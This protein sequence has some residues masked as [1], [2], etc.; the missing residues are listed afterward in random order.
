MLGTY[1]TFPELLIWLPLLAGVACFF[2]KKEQAAKAIALLG[3]LLVL[4]VSIVT[5]FYTDNTQYGSYNQVNYIWL[6]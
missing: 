2:A 4:S 6:K 5:L 1:I 3:S